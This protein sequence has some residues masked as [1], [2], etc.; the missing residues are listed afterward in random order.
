MNT[1]HS[2]GLSLPN[3]LFSHF[4]ISL[5]SI[6]ICLILFCLQFSALGITKTSFEPGLATEAG[7]APPNWVVNPSNFQFNMSLVVRVNYSSVPTNDPDNIVGVF[8]GSELR[9]VA[10]S[11]NIGGNMYY[12]IT[13]YSNVFTGETLKF[14]AYYQ[15]DDQVYATPETTVFTHNMSTGSIASPFWINIDPTADFPPALNPIPA[16]TTL[17]TLAFD[18]VNLNNYLVSLDNDPVIWSATAGANL[19]A[20][21]VNGILTVTPV[22]NSWTGTD[23]V[24]I[25]VTENTANQYSASVTAYFTVQTFYPAP[26]FSQIPP[27]SVFLGGTFSSFDLDNYLT[28]TGPCRAFGMAV[29]PFS[30]TVAN[31]GWATVAPGAQSMTVVARPLFS[32]IQL[33]GAGAELA[34]FVNGTLVGKASPSG[35]APNVYY[36]LTLANL[37]SGPITFKFYHAE[38]QYLYEKITTQNF[39]PNGSVGT[40]SNPFA[41]QFSPIVPTLAS[42][43]T[44][45]VSIVDAQW[46][47]VFPINYYVWDCAYPD[48]RRDTVTALYTVTVNYSPEITSPAAVNFQENTCLELYDTQTIDGSSS[49]GSGLTYAL[50]GGDDAAKFSINAVNGKLSWLNF[51]PDFEIPADADLNNQ[52]LVKIRVTNT[53]NLSDTLALTVTVTDNATETFNPQITGGS[54]QC[55]T[56]SIVLQATGGATY[57]WS[58]GATTAS[59]TVNTSGNYTVTVTNAFACTG[60]VST[61]VNARPAITA[62]GSNTPVCVNAPINLTS[63]P[64]GGSGV[65]ASFA[66][67]GPNGYVATV[68]NPPSFAATSNAAGAYIVTVTDSQGCTSTAS[69]TISVSGSSAPSIVAAGT[70][71]VCVGA[72]ITLSSTPSGGSG[73]YPTYQWAGPNSYVSSVQNPSPFTAVAASGG[74]YTV[75]VTD[76]LGCTAVA[77][78]VIQVNSKPNITASSNT[79]VCVGSTVLITSNPSGGAA[80]YTA[81]SWT[82][83]NSFVSSVEDPVGFTAS[84]VAQGVYRVTVTDNNGCTNTSS[85]TLVVKALPSI[86]AGITG[87][88]CTGGTLKLNS[89]PTGGTT[90]YS[91]FSWVGPNSYTSNIEDPVAIQLINAAAGIYYVTV[92]DASG[93]TA[94]SSVTASINPLP[95]I[96]AANSGPICAG[97][98]LSVSSTPSG[99]TAP[100]AAFSWSGPSGYTAGVEDPAPFTSSQNSNGT[101]QVIV[102]DAKGCTATASTT[103]VVNSKPVITA[104]NNGPFCQGTTIMLTSTPSAGSGTY[105]SFSWTGP[106]S[107]TSSL[108]DPT[109]FSAIVA[110]SGIY[111]VTVTDNLGCTGTT[112]TTV[113]V[114]SN[115]LPTVTATSNSPICTAQSLSL[116][117]TPSGGSGQYSSYAWVGPNGYTA[118]GQFPASFIANTS[119]AGTYSVTLTDNKGC[120]AVGSTTVSVSGPTVTMSHTNLSCFNSN[121]GTA[122]VSHSGGAPPYTYLWSNNASTATITGLAAGTYTVT[123]T[124]SSSGACTATGSV[125]ISQVPAVSAS[126]TQTTQGCS[127]VPSGTATAIGVGGSTPYTYLWPNG[128]TT[129]TATGLAS[130]SYTVTVT[131][132]GGCTA[133]ATAVVVEE[134]G[135]TLNALSN[136]GPI[137]PGSAVA[138]KALS[139]STGNAGISYTWTGG[140]TA[141]LPNGVS[142]GNNPSIPAF[143]AALVEGTYTVTVTG[144]LGAC[145][146]SATYSIDINDAIAPVMGTCPSNIVVGNTNNQ[147]YATVNWTVPTATDNCNNVQVV[148]SS[149]SA[150]GSSF[151]V[152]TTQT[153]Q[154]TASDYGGN[155]VSCTF[156]VTVNDTQLPTLSCPSGTLTFGTDDNFCA[157]TNNSTALNATGSDNCALKTGAAGLYYTASGAT[158]GTGTTLN[159]QVFQ[160]G[161]TT[162]VWTAVDQSNNTRTCAYTVVINDND[163]PMI[164]ACSSDQTVSTTSNGTGDCTGKIPNLVAGVVAT[165]NCTASNALII[166]QSPAANSTIGSQHGVQQ[167]VTITV[168][169]AYNNTNFCSRVVTLADTEVPLWVNCASQMILNNDVDKCGANIFF[170]APGASDNCSGTVTVTQISGPVPGV[171]LPIGQTQ[172]VVFK[173]VDGAGNSNTCQTIIQ[174]QDSQK[175]AVNCPTGIQTFGTTNNCNYLAGAALNATASDNCSVSSLKNSVNNTSSISG[176]LFPL[177]TTVVTWT[178]TDPANNTETC[179]STI[180]IFDDDTPTITTCP[181][182]RNINTS[183]NGVGD[184]TG[185]VPNM[186]SELF[187]SD[188]CTATG[189]LTITQSQPAGSAFG[190]QHNDTRVVTFTAQDAAGNV[191]TCQNVLTLKDNESPI[192]QT[193]PTI[194]QIY[195]T[196]PNQCSTN[197]NWAIPTAIDNCSSA[198]VVQTGGPTQG[199]SLAVGTTYVVTYNATDAYTNSSTCQ[200]SIQVLDSQTPLLLCP[201][202]VQDFDASANCDYVASAALNAVASDNCGIASTNGLVNSYNNTNSIIGASFPLG[203]TIVNW[204]ATDLS[205]NTQTCSYTI[206]VTDHTAPIISIC[207]PSRNLNTSSNGTGDCQITIPDLLPELIVADN[208]T[209]LTKTQT[210][211]AGTAFGAVHG[212][213]QVVQFVATDNVGNATTCEMSITVIDDELPTLTPCPANISVLTTDQYPCFS[214]LTWS[215]P[216]ASDNC[217]TPVFNFK[218]TN[219]NNTVYGPVNIDPQNAAY[220]FELGNSVVQYLVTDENANSATCSFLVTV[221]IIKSKVGNLVWHDQNGNGIQDGGEP[222]LGGVSVSL[223][224]TSQCLGTAIS[225][226]TTTDANGV[227]AFNDVVP[228]E[229]HLVFGTPA[230]AYVPTAAHEGSDDATDSDREAM[231]I[232]PDF[233]IL[234]A[235]TILN[236]DAGFYIPAKIGNL[237]WD[238]TNGN[239]LQD[240]GEPGIAGVDVLLN[241]TAGDGNIVSLAT[242]TNGSGNYIFN[243]LTPGAYQVSFITPT[244]G[245]VRTAAND[246][247]A[248]ADSN[249]SDADLATGQSIVEILVSGEDNSTY[250]AGF[251]LPPS[252]GNLAWIDQ[253]ANGIQ[254]PDEQPLPGVSVTLTGIDG[255]GAAVTQTTLTD[256]DGKYLF[257]NLLPG[258]YNLTFAPPAGSTF[259]LTGHDLGGNDALDNDANESNGGMTINETLTSGEHNTTYDA[260]Y[261]APPGLGDYVWL[262]DN[263]NGVQDPGEP[264]LSGV[265][266]Q[267]LDGASTPVAVDADGNA[268]STKISASNGYYEFVNLIPGNYKVKFE[269]PNPKYTLTNANTGTDDAQD[270]DADFITHITPATFVTSNSFDPKLDAGYYVKAR[271]GNLVWHDLNGNGLQDGGEPGLSGIQVT[272]SGTNGFGNAVSVNQTTDASG[273]YLFENVVPG[274]YAIHFNTPA[275]YVPSTLDLGSDDAVDSDFG[276]MG[277]TPAFEVTSGDTILTFDAG[278]YKV[279]KI[280][281]LVWDDTNGNGLQDASE[282]GIAGVDV[283]LTGT[284]GDGAVVNL[285]TTT[286]TTG[287]YTFE[288]LT[289]GA[290]QVTFITPT[291]GYVRTAAND[292]DGTADANDSDA[293]LAS[294]QS[295]VE[296]IVSG[297]DNPTY[298]AG[299]YLPPSIGDYVWE[300]QNANGKQE[301]DEPHLVGA[302]VQLVGVN[303]QGIAVNANTSTDVDGHFEFNNLLPGVYHLVFPIPAGYDA[304][305]YLDQTGNDATDSDVNPNN[306]FKTIDETLVS[307]EHNHTYD[308]GFYKF[309]TFGNLVWQD[310]N[311]N[312]IQDQNEPGL[313]NTNIT[314]NGTTG[315]GTTLTLSAV[316]GPNGNFLFQN[317]VPGYYQVTFQKPDGYWTS[318]LGSVGTT[319]DSDSDASLTSGA[320]ALTLLSSGEVDLSWD[321]GY[322]L[323]DYGDLPTSYATVAGPSNPAFHYLDPNLYLGSCVDAEFNG[324]DDTAVG[325]PVIG[326]CAG[327]SDDENGIEFITPLVGGVAACIKVN[328]HNTSNT[329][330]VL[331]GWIDFNGDGDLL[332]AGEALGLT[333]NGLIPAG[334]V[335]DAIYCFDVPANTAFQNGSMYARF[336]L[337]PTGGLNSFGPAVGGEVEDYKTDVG[338]IGNLVWNDRNFNGNQDAGEPGIA[339]VPVKMT[340]SGPDGNLSTTADNRE[341]TTTTD[342]S[343]LYHFSVIL[344]GNYSIRVLTPAMMTPTRLNAGINTSNDNDGEALAADLAE[345]EQLFTILDPQNMATGEN[346]IGDDGSIAGFSDAQNEENHDFGFAYLDYG[347]LPEDQSYHTTLNALGAVHTT[348]PQLTLGACVDA[349]REGMPDGD[350]GVY[351]ELSSNAGDG[352][353]GINTLSINTQDCVGTPLGI[354]SAASYQCENK[355]ILRTI[356]THGSYVYY[357]VNGDFSPAI[358]A[359]GGFNAI[360]GA[361]AIVAN[362]TNNGAFTGNIAA[363]EQCVAQKDGVDPAL[364]TIG[365]T[366][367]LNLV[368]FDKPT[369]CNDDENGIRFETP[370]IPGY[371]ACVRVSAKNASLSAAALQGWIDWN[372]D[373]QLD[374]SE[375]LQFVNNGLVPSGGLE[376]AQFCFPVPLTAKFNAGRVYARFRLSPNGG[377]TPDG[378]AVFG[379]DEMPLGEVEDYIEEVGKVGNLVW[380]DSNFDGLQGNPTL[381]PGMNN[382]AIQ[383]TWAGPDGNITTASDNRVYETMT[384]PVNGKD[385]VYYFCGL[386]D[387]TYKLTATTPTDF[388]QTLIQQGGNTQLDANDFVLG[389][390]FSWPDVANLVLNEQ[391]VSDMPGALPNFPDAHDDQT[392]D[393]GF[394]AVDFGDNT[395]ANNTLLPNGAHATL[396]PGLFLGLGA[397][398]EPDGMP[399]NQAGTQNTGGDDADPS[400]Y[401]VGTVAAN[402]DD[403][404]GFKLLTPLV[405][406]YEACCEIT[407]NVTAPY[408]PAYVSMWIDYNGNNTFD[409]SEKVFFTTI[410]NINVNSSA[411]QAPTGPATQRYCFYVPTDASFNGGAAQIRL[412]LNT[413]PNIQPTG[414]VIFGEVE[415]YWQP[416]SLLG[417]NVWI[418]SDI[419]GDQDAAEMALPGVPV[420]LRWFG[421]DQ[422]FN[423][424]DDRLYNTTTDANGKYQIRG[425]IPSDYRIYPFKY[426][427]VANAL[428][429]IAPLNKILTIPNLAP[430][431]DNNDSDGAPFIPLQVPNLI[432]ALMPLNENG[433][434]DNNGQNGFP[435]ANE[436]LSLDFGFITNPVIASTLEISG[437]QKPS[438]GICGNFD[439]I[440]TFCLQ[441]TGEVPVNMLQATLDLASQN[442]LGSMF[443]GFVP[444]ATPQI[445]SSTAHQNPV[446]NNLY[447]GSTVTTLFNGASGTLWPGEKVCVQF[448]VALQPDA[449]GAPLSPG[450]QVFVHTVAVNFQGEPIPDFYNGGQVNVTDLSDDGHE[451]PTTNPYAP[452]D[453]GGYNDPTPLTDCWE[454]SQPLVQNDVVHVSIDS[455]CLAYIEAGA[456]LEGEA[457]NCTELIYPM[458][459]F[460][461]VVLKNEQTGVV[462]PNP[463]TAAYIGQTIVVE[464]EHIVSCNKVWGK[465]LLE[466]K[467]A[468]AITCPPDIT[469]ACSE[470]LQP[471]NTGTVQ[472]QDCSA[473]TTQITEE[474]QDNGECG[475]PRQLIQRT[476]IVK[477]A[478]NNQSVCAHVITVEPFSMVEMIMPADVTVDCESAYLNPAATQPVT[479]G[480]PTIN[481]APIGTSLCSASLGYT[482]VVNQSCEGSYEI[483][484]TWLVANTCLPTG[485]GNPIEYL[486]RIRVKDFGGPQFTCPNNITVSVDPF[487]C[488]ATAALPDVIISEGCSEIT[489]LKARVTGVDPSSG[490]ITTFTIPGT[491]GDFPNNNYWTPDT[492]AIFAFTQCLPNNNTYTVRYTASDNCANTSSCEFELTVKDL[493]PPVATCDQ[494]TQVALGGDGVSLIDASTFNDGSKDNCASEVKFKARRMLANAC[495]SDTVFYDQVKFCCSDIN[496]TLQVVFRV[497]DVDVPAGEVSIDTFEGHFNDC[498][499]QVL[500]E[501]KIHPVCTT[502]ANVTVSCENFDPSL[503]SYG[504][505]EVSDNCCLDTSKVYQGQ[506]GL[507]HTINY[508]LFDTLCNKG[509]IT[510]NF[511]AVDCAGLT[512]TCTQRVVVNY[513]QDYYVRFPNDVIISSCDGTGNYGAPTFFGEDCEQLGV[514]FED[515]VFTVV[516]DACFE[517]Q[518]TWKIINWCTFNPNQPLVAVPNP[519]PNAISSNA[520][521]LPGP[522]VA[523]LGTPDPWA[524]TVVKVLPTDPQ[525]TNYSTFYNANANGYQYKQII[526]VI[527]TQDPVIS[528]C[529]DTLVPMCDYTLNNN[530]LWNADY[531]YDTIIGQHDL[532]EGPVDL[533]IST[534]DSCTGPSVS[535]HYLLYLDLNNDGILE[536]VINSLNPPVAGTVN[537]GNVFTPNYQG[538]TA[539][540]FD[541]RNL[542]TNR[543]YYFAMKNTLSGSN[544]V[545]SV[546]WNTQQAP[547]TFVVPEFPHGKHKIEWIVS[548][549]CGNE[550]I[551]TYDFEVK[552]CKKPTAVCLNG[553]STNIMPDGTLTLWASD[554]LQYAEDNCTP[555]DQILIGVQKSSVGTTFP[556]DN[557]GQPVKSVSFTCA[558]LGTQTVQIWAKDKAGNADFCETY[559]IVQDNS[560]NCIT[561]STA[562][563]VAGILATETSN[564]VLDGSVEITGSGNAIPSFTFATMSDNQGLYNFNGIP[565]SSNSTITPLKDDNP[566]NGVSTYDLVLISRHVLGIQALDSPYKIIAADANKSYSVT[567]FDIVEIRK[568][569]LGIYDKLPNNT[570]WRFVDKSYVFP[571]V[572]NPFQEIFPENKSI[573]DIQSNRFA[574]DFVAVKVGDVNNNAA[575]NQLVMSDDRSGGTL[576]FDINDRILSKSGSGTDV[577]VGSTFTVDLKPAELV[578]G[579]QFTMNFK[580]LEVVDITP[581]AN[582]SMGN[583]GVFA[584]AITTSYEGPHQ[585]AFSVTFRALQ[586]GKLS[587]MLSVSSRITRAEAYPAFAKATGNSAEANA[588]GDPAFAKATADKLNIA[589]RFNNGASSTVTGVGFELYQ[590]QPNPFVDK[591][592]IGFHL[593][594]EASAQA[595]NLIPVTLSIF[596]ETGRL[597]YTQK[598]A[599]A[600]GYN[601]FAIEKALLN[602]VGMMYYKLE[603]ATDSATMK[604]I[605]AK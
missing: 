141:G 231:G 1:T 457:D 369:A 34:A 303:G 19:T 406:G 25:T 298:D 382:V 49:E 562:A 127:T 12:F 568:L 358:N 205:G 112:S 307:G 78:K 430:A 38:N 245:Y 557:N 72:T 310:Y 74:S 104:A 139:S 383:L 194:T 330:A 48:T 388:V 487:T 351:D 420:Q 488:C 100:Y 116:S 163:A 89:T 400:G 473:T 161:S 356:N 236:I 485:P 385:G 449:A 151:A 450:L 297:E 384:A 271:I 340:W 140:S 547:S 348:S 45:N 453:T 185:G 543:L 441:N 182:S 128:Q 166:T 180:V 3:K 46:Q 533:S 549:G 576:Y 238:D 498:M 427:G 244:G 390:I 539:R 142:T 21:I 373:G 208:C 169:D 467:L 66:W 103:A 313:A 300:D 99:G 577:P 20:S 341:Y 402:G 302:L 484:R 10:T 95:G 479:T 529:P 204:T 581:G 207:P 368:C 491:L 515:Q 410:N 461:K 334:G 560:G 243:G 376:D 261:Y 413:T 556:V 42:N 526:K 527:D 195:Q 571:M 201:A 434:A 594:A 311:G 582:M 514:T 537:E 198:S 322:Y 252:I 486:Q 546:A 94:T 321:A 276:A 397:D 176:V 492:L 282:P 56:G 68:Q 172:T 421:E 239:G 470:S 466:D 133:T 495:Q 264:A 6:F 171:Y 43:G 111:K 288:N 499:V 70:S 475:T 429:G 586:G 374:N 7:A 50:A 234:T 123:L 71:P 162:L 518:R 223:I 512:G 401:Q 408:L 318:P 275:G 191:K 32:D 317:L 210:P 23:T 459:G 79:P 319:G 561:D 469:V 432:N 578:S 328:A 292:P 346:G 507:I 242:T 240:G 196:S 115:P 253:N 209:I 287:N 216:A 132:S 235:D 364:V 403:E 602:T 394:V 494:F 455:T 481:G 174:I 325:I 326:T 143:T 5:P 29:F 193:C 451:P 120:S 583:F 589:L 324:G 565:K 260:G 259:E 126:I 150:P 419:D 149:G 440:F 580:G 574:E 416:L 90:P 422:V 31:P 181:P 227:Y 496:D 541:H 76:N 593:P 269:H 305:T 464:V 105:S 585:G 315:N 509:T 262:D 228:G 523:P 295:V 379:S 605:Q 436:N 477:D 361:T 387:G 102:T 40:I 367:S 267:L 246:P 377:L 483:Y 554:F 463:L 145:S 323:T 17:Q 445:S 312:G 283:L 530:Q 237:V 290:Y 73:V 370:L 279:A 308:A 544:K 285:G 415:D 67:S 158:T 604:M 83:P 202:G 284:A 280:G 58:T 381:E 333:N 69:T 460:Y 61:T 468:P 505:P 289:P 344:T 53:L 57:L 411:P 482:D 106:N 26:V 229:Y 125:T 186:V 516:P 177:G 30:G 33:A 109:P 230:G 164:T 136:I 121:N 478:W 39:I 222:G 281:N 18:P 81:Y 65:Y 183:S 337:S 350:A 301:T 187:A 110:A 458:G 113:S 286:N 14:K 154:Y 522:I 471:V 148:R 409:A 64:S 35:I 332:D 476:F 480:Q 497:Y 425:L 423:S 306:G 124:S 342:I 36:N 217:A 563:K 596:D 59:I 168:K 220:S 144:T 490:I 398:A 443:L 52:Y 391:G 273:N 519:T 365:G 524:P 493:I 540:R 190:A 538:G 232:T 88:T 316:S 24:H 474:V 372:G 9:G 550:T 338:K 329:T 84:S 452:G 8:V 119:H 503:W 392:H 375:A 588:T 345:V 225:S 62:S 28:Y 241:G 27:Q 206:E 147:C 293:D 211:L 395:T 431:N 555:A 152:G 575:V 51:S 418:D 600:K 255:Q 87:A 291:G 545:A 192:F 80:P 159:G 343:G 462:I 363:L 203:S 511:R 437:V 304:A 442:A 97:A 534:T 248:N 137:C 603:T 254:E 75:T 60:V 447:N 510:R 85:T 200:F 130:G 542:P 175:P 426:T 417:N 155:S 101:Y 559:V 270:C 170:T 54:A 138:S 424:A 224:G 428:G 584:D 386:I 360:L 590:N 354:V 22:S 448:S 165:D 504:M 552:D 167:L 256:F 15:P 439:A 572:S 591:T 531:F 438:S 567:S 508:S 197:V 362:S 353:D 215:H 528:N 573:A 93:C 601:S 566:L 274:N 221:D 98:Q 396:V 268:I 153:I 366:I 446:L 327:G 551:C 263:A 86:T 146:S 525:A 502:P 513:E 178:A 4:K 380:E 122:T 378:P 456:V 404:D 339:N 599:F 44:V 2:K 389:D 157:Y 13:A 218:I 277:N 569:I 63:T 131:E 179:V 331:Q 213:V 598:G 135:F 506:I 92:T 219:P 435:D 548:D 536:T 393:A 500:V 156:T 359:A 129:A 444:G 352:D 77:T 91:T 117:A 357:V 465:I 433:L 107:F 371:D 226:T 414:L 489:E 597:V 55:F 595:G 472:I 251:Y 517:I 214:S 199:S 118:S 233:T 320:S 278:F 173:A 520:Q 134:T 592:V 535:I 405:P 258:V 570:S 82:G 355:L 265:V 347:D 564:G 249:D 349:E 272:L 553:L 266:M 160:V 336:R 587:E 41:I 558:D 309:T 47:G 212:D 314:L 16:D 96:S 250:D 335:T 189:S 407:T 188:N 299:F 532:C 521:N 114:S 501:D 579:Y 294:G 412:R 37:A 454:I 257:N 247:D 108:E 11:T 184:C 296:I 399:D